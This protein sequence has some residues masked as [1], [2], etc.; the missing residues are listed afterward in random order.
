MIK[1][2]SEISEFSILEILEIFFTWNNDTGCNLR[3]K[4][5]KEMNCDKNLKVQILF[6]TKSKISEIS[7]FSILPIPKIEHWET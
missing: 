1:K 6:R 3:F 7:E 5:A 2:I 4:N